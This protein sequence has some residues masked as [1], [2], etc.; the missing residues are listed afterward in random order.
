MNNASYLR[1]TDTSQIF[2]ILK[3][4]LC[5]GVV[6]IHSKVSPSIICDYPLYESF[7]YVFARLIVGRL[8]VP[9]FFV[10]SGFFFFTRLEERVKGQFFVYKLKTRI[11]S[12]VIPYL[13]ANTITYLY[14]Y[15]LRILGNDYL[16]GYNSLWT[17]FW[18]HPDHGLPVDMPLW[19][20][21]D[22]FV[23]TLISP[24]LFFL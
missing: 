10:M 21:R 20:L 11:K 19:Y 16:E 4:F 13:I 15:L 7:Q 6:I 8:C 1:P 17:C 14:L 18:G 23:I 3:C 12:I 9:F 24:L 22:L 5:I 2:N